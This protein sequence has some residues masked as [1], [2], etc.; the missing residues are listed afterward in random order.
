MN[1]KKLT[2]QKEIENTLN[3]HSAENGS[4]TPDFI[5]ARY[6]MDCLKAFDNAALA[7]SN[8]YGNRDKSIEDAHRFDVRDE[9]S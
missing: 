2:L 3:R 8:W 5:L 1:E 9:K 4:N 6:L 7:R